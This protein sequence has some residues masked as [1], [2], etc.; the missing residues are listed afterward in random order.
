MIRLTHLHI[1]TT[2]WREPVSTDEEAQR[3][4]LERALR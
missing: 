3:M 2:V 4:Y 1:L